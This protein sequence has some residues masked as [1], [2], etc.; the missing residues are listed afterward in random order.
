MRPAMI[1]LADLSA[2]ALGAFL[3]AVPL[4]ELVLS[5]PGVDL[6]NAIDDPVVLPVQNRDEAGHG[7]EHESGRGRL[8]DHDGKVLD[9]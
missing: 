7:G 1:T 5:R 2:D 8:L 9:A 4:P 6:A 3:A